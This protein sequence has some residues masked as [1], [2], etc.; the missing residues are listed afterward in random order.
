MSSGHKVLEG[1]PG[2]GA[3]RDRVAR[4]ATHIYPLSIRHIDPS[5]VRLERYVHHG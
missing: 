1:Q 2:D 5:R 3:S 4:A